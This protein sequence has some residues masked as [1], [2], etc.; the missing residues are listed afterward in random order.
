MNDDK[1]N[2]RVSST[3]SV[4]ANK[5]YDTSFLEAYQPPSK[6]SPFK[7]KDIGYCAAAKYI[8]VVEGDR[9]LLQ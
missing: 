3:L 8:P 5:D 7:K 6:V 9:K 1:E 4:N 2:C